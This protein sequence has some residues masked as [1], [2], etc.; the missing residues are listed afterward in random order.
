MR[1]FRRLGF[2]T[3]ARRGPRKA[4]HFASGIDAH[5]ALITGATA[6]KDESADHNLPN[7]Q[8]CEILLRG[9]N[10]IQGMRARYDTLVAQ[11]V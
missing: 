7:E 2:T 3:G 1:M 10:H 11:M 5:I 8:Q 6:I 4:R 9:L